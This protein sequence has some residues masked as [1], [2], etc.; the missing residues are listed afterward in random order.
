MGLKDWIAP[1]IT[2]LIG[3]STIFISLKNYQAQAAAKP[4]ELARLE[5]WSKL[6]TEAGGPQRPTRPR[7]AH[8]RPARRPRKLPG[9]PQACVPRIEAA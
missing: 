8:L 2:L 4:S 1:F 3:A 9:L 6:L 5:L 7:K